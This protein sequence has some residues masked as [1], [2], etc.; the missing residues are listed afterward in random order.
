MLCLVDYVRQKRE[1][2]ISNKQKV[3]NQHIWFNV[4]FPD[5]AELDRFSCCDCVVL[6]I[7]WIT[8]SIDHK[9]VWT[10]N[11]LHTKYLLRMEFVIQ[12]NIEHNII[13]VWNL[14]R[15]WSIAT[16]FYE[17]PPIISNLKHFL[18]VAY[19]SR[20]VFISS[21]Q[22]F[23]G[24][25]VAKIPQTSNF[26]HLL[27]W[28]LSSILS[29]RPNHSNILFFKPLLMVFYCSLILCFTSEVLPSCPTLN[30]YSILHNFCL[31]FSISILNFNYWLSTFLE[32]FSLVH[33]IFLQVIF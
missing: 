10:A 15:G 28:E 11:L 6:E 2:S 18:L 33:S 1:S 5:M 21:L 13:A 24:H 22:V 12:I 8:N 17:W 20:S 27:G 9:G 23:L 26:K 4:C 29:R 31:V 32:L 25:V 3:Y 16:S 19:C 7:I 14:T 30:S